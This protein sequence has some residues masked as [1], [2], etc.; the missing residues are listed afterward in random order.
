MSALLSG[1]G[2]GLTVIAEESKA[3][4]RGCARR[5]GLSEGQ[6]FCSARRFPPSS[7]ELL[8]QLRRPVVLRG[9]GCKWPTSPWDTRPTTCVQRSTGGLACRQRRHRSSLD[10]ARS[11]RRATYA[12]LR[13]CGTDNSAGPILGWRTACLRHTGDD[14]FSLGRNRSRS[15]SPRCSSSTGFGETLAADQL[16]SARRR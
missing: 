4:T 16:L 3:T 7:L 5:A 13:P 6:G 14:L 15:G 11:K 8:R 2:L 9:G 12:L 1:Q 10:A